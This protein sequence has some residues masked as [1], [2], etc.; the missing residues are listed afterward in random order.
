MIRILE[1]FVFKMFSKFKWLKSFGSCYYHELLVLSR[2]SLCIYTKKM[3]I[4]PD[5]TRTEMR[6]TKY[7]TH[8]TVICKR[9]NWVIP[10]SHSLVP[11]ERNSNQNEDTRAFASARIT[12]CAL[13]T[14]QFKLFH[15][16]TRR[17]NVARCRVLRFVEEVNS[18]S[19]GV[20]L[21]K[22]ILPGCTFYLIIFTSIAS[23][24]N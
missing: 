6:R 23:L 17:F 18:S 7:I 13:N 2:M 11:R 16:W 12:Y 14:I 21:I 19:C 20:H 5:E 1:N 9:D 8:T 24:K 3:F 4:Y 10:H 15:T 22:A